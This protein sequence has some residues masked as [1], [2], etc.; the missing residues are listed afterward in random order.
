MPDIQSLPDSQAEVSRLAASGAS[1]LSDASTTS[2][3]PGELYAAMYSG[4]NADSLVPK[5]T[6]TGCET[7]N[8]AK[9]EPAPEPVKPDK[10]QR[11]LHPHPTSPIEPTKPDK[12]DVPGPLGPSGMPKGESLADPDKLDPDKVKPRRHSGPNIQG[13]LPGDSLPV[14]SMN[15]HSDGFHWSQLISHEN[16]IPGDFPS[17][18]TPPQTAPSTNPTD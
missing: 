4:S 16:K 6:I 13:A 3:T 8:G 12:P 17:P 10:P 18:G 15:R 11:P 1:S 14:E 5:M 9:C 7:A 2:Q